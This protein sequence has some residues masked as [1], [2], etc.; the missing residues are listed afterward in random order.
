MAAPQQNVR[1]EPPFG[2]STVSDELLSELGLRVEERCWTSARCGTTVTHCGNTYSQILQGWR[3]HPDEARWVRGRDDAAS[4]TLDID[5]LNSRGAT[6]T[7]GMFMH[8][9]LGA[10]RFLV[11]EG[12]LRMCLGET[13]Q[14][15]GKS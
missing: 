10:R 1:E 14:S 6:K 12:L 13:A 7:S 4:H 15:S 8:C 9:G 3:W 2:Y 5:E 11:G